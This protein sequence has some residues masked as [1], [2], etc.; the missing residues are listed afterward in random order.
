MAYTKL[1][2]GLPLELKVLEGP[3]EGKYN[4]RVEEV[5][6]KILVIGAPY[7][8]GEVI[9]LR[10]GT[11]VSL[12]YW[13]ELSAYSFESVIMQ[14]I[15]VPFPMF[16]LAMPDSVTKIQRRNFVRI[17]VSYPFTFRIVLEDSLSDMFEG[18]MLDLSGGGIQFKTKKYMDNGSLLDAHIFLPNRVLEMPLRVTRVERAEDRSGLFVVSSEFYNINER[19]RDD[20]IRCVFEIQRE[21]RKKGL[22]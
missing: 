21:M 20:I 6:E 16:V 15:A 3:Y 8:Q 13:D 11:E 1:E 7:E 2:F 17:P 19:M 12:T 5:G 4:S 22:V 10:E 14:R 9:P 18:S